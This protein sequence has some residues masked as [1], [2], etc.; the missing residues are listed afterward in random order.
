MTTDDYNIFIA[1]FHEK[2]D[3]S[4]FLYRNS[5][6]TFYMNCF[7]PRNQFPDIRI[8][9]DDHIYYIP[10]T[11]YVIQNNEGLCFVRIGPTKDKFWVLG[12]AFLQN[13]Y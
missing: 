5:Q 12:V 2:L 6:G 11:S 4:L 3:E 1:D 9:I 7:D 10:P 8:Q 13:Y